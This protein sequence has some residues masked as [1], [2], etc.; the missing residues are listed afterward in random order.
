MSAT[1]LNDRLPRHV[2]N[3][4]YEYHIFIERARLDVSRE[5]IP[6]KPEKFLENQ[7]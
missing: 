6:I 4:A 1:P 7:E 5:N 3:R 2:Y